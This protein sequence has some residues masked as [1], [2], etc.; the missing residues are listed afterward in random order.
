[1]PHDING[2]EL[3]VGDIVTV[4]CKVT[5]VHQQENACNVD[6]TALDGPHGEYKPSFVANSRSVVL[7]EQ[8]N[9]KRAAMRQEPT[10]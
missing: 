5:A 3:N 9:W 4:R 10:T 6:L 1:M 8:A 7:L 2:S